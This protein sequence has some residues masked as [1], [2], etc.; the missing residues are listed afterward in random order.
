MAL[1]ILSPERIE[2]A[3][4]DSKASHN[5]REVVL[6]PTHRKKGGVR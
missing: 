3:R 4:P 1:H 5:S 2:R 6:V